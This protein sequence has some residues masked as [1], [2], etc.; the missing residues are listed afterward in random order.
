MN[1][2]RKASSKKHQEFWYKLT[3]HNQKAVCKL[4]EEND[5][6]QFILSKQGQTPLDVACFFGMSEVVSKLLELGADPEYQSQ[7][8]L[9]D[10]PLHAVLRG[11]MRRQ[12]VNI[13]K[14]LLEAGADPNQA[15]ERRGGMTPLML[16][17]DISQVGLIDKAD[18]LIHAGADICQTDST[19]WIA[20]HHAVGRP[21]MI[22]YLVKKGGNV[23]AQSHGGETPLHIAAL[24]GARL[25]VRTLLANGADPNIKNESGQSV[26]DYVQ[27]ELSLP[28]TVEENPIERI[29]GEWK[30]RKMRS[31]LK[32]VARQSRA[33]G[34]APGK[35][36][37]NKPKM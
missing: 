9:S 6:Y 16:L 28:G 37:K 8:L 3:T 15:N 2:Y 13:V 5:K 10:P 20:L 14:A 4:L 26:W 32:E 7:S 12:S 18:A 31:D 22:R 30:Q 29:L 17:G 33:K 24:L 19:G 36:G 1:A 35:V 34:K 23:N 11:G 27:H 25:S 21:E